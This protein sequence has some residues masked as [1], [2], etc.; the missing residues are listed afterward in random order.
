MPLLCREADIVKKQR[1]E[2]IVKIHIV[3]NKLKQIKR[4]IY[5]SKA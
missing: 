3:W 4:I 5:Y 1:P 2:L